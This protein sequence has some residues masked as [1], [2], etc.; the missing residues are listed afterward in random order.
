MKKRVTGFGGIFFKSKNP[1]ELQAWYDKHL[2]IS[3]LPHSPW[4][5]EDSV[6]LFEW[7][8]LENPERKAYSVFGI[9]PEDTGYFAPSAAPFMF[10]FRVDDLDK[11][12]ADLAKEG[13]QQQGD[14]QGLP[15][16]RFARISDPEGNQIELWEPAEGF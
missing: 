16:G 9:F 6:P 2:N 15:F 1:Q 4:G 11:V 8:D 3:P 7:R 12:L 14:I 13:I 10:N 5:G